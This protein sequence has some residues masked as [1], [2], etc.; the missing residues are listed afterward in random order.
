MLEKLIIN[1]LGHLKDIQTLSSKEKNSIK[2]NDK[3]LY[4]ETDTSKRKFVVSEKDSSWE[5]ISFQFLYDA[6]NEFSSIRLANSSD[7]VK[8]KGRSSFIMALFSQLPFVSVTQKN[9]KKAIM[10]NQFFTDQLP[11]IN[12]NQVLELLEEVIEK[13]LDLKSLK[14]SYPED[15]VYRLKSRA[16]QGLK[17][18]G[19][20]DSQYVINVGLIEEYRSSKVRSVILKKQMLKHTYFSIVYELLSKFSDL[21]KVY[22]FQAIKE[23]GML[24]VKNS[25]GD[26]L[27]RDS[28]ADVRTRYMLSW[29]QEVDLLDEE[30][31]PIMEES[32]RPLLI[33][34][35]QDYLTARTEPL[36]NH[37]IGKLVRNELPNAI[38][39]LPFIDSNTYSVKGSVGQGNWATVPW[40]AILNKNVTPSTQRGYYIVYLFSEN[41]KELYL[42]FAQGITETS[43]N[44]MLKMNEEIRENIVMDGVKKSNDY[45]L[46]EGA[47]ARGYVESTAAYIKYS[48]DNMPSENQLVNDLEKMISYYESFIDYKKERREEEMIVIPHVN[49]KEITDHIHSYIQSKGFY[50][51]KE[52]VINLYL[53][54]K[55]KPFVILS[56]ISGTGK[57]KMVQ[58]F[59]ESVG[60]TERNG[61]FTLIPVRPDWSDG[62]DLLGYVDIKGDFKKGP[63]TSV[64]ERAMDD[65]TKPFF[66]LLDEMNLARVEYYF[67]DLLSVMESR[68]REDREIITTPVLA[69]EVDGRDII[70]P[71]NVYIVGTVNMDETTHPFSKKV[72]DRA[73]TIE[74]NRVQLNHFAFL[75]DLEEQEPLSIGNHSLAGDSL[76]LKDVYKD[77]I[78]VIT[79]VTEV[80]V[81]INVQLE[82]IGAQV[83]YRVRDEICFY[84]I[85]SEKDN[86]LTFEEA[87]DQSILQKILPRISGSDE[88]VWD[89]LK[90]L[91]EIFTNQV[92][93]TDVL[94]EFDKAIY[95][96][97]AQKVVDMIRRY[98]LDGF[99]S[100]WIGS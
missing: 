85:Y 45:F 100:F 22:K 50:Y 84:V 79:K 66:V 73:N 55:T 53:S 92:Y 36:T 13:G 25:T 58:W 24:I 5:L 77:N 70:L 56:G 47:K 8:A 49:E 35:M 28:V 12:L 1:Y 9:G 27:M 74:F 6:W 41:M 59:A 57:T 91:Y 11:E 69:F 44:E 30:L 87:M 93:D 89:T 38:C 3:G 4:V 19:F 67:S 95:P 62:S 88:R 37:P 14:Q 64:L 52:E 94:P 15:N 72:L 46:G 81:N 76:H 31:N 18:L 99:T 61:Q 78:A 90:G 65:P 75:E 60:A 43:R 51:K 10:L 16:R 82:S 29:M 33:K 54:L 32:I 20:I 96:K 80:L 48:L 42:T 23:L 26:N 86:L 68:R 21:E 17:L 83:G 34:T 63:L 98:Q 7:F 97:S 2:L 40:L 39:R 71:S